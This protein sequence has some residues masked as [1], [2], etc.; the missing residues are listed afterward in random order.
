MEDDLPVRRDLVIPGRELTM[1]AS[2]A[3]GPGGQNV[4]KVA[5]RVTL[6]WDAAGSEA[7]DGRQKARLASRL[8]NRINA[9][10]EI[11]LHAS[12]HRSQ[13][14]NRESARRRLADLVAGALRRPRRRIPTRPGT[15]AVRRRLADKRRRARLKKTRSAPDVD[16]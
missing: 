2:R 13:A 11:V 16:D 14:R 7:L 8:G 12:E 9:R 1:T 4:N 3:G 15:A 6:R 5:T 10:G